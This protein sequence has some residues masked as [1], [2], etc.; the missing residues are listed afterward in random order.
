MFSVLR[1]RTIAATLAFAI[2]VLATGCSGATAVPT[3]PVV[4]VAIA[5][6]TFN[7]NDVTVPQ[8]ATVRWT[9]T[10]VS[11]RHTILPAVD[12]A[13]KPHDS[14][15]KNGESVSTTFTKPGDYA[16]YC[17]IHGSKTAGQRGVIHVTNA[18]AGG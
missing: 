4:Q 18:T 8:G 12:G 16:Y 7:P 1:Q 13:F 5:D 9:N 6:L 3:G 2:A 15:I 14:L 10:S 17:S 11:E